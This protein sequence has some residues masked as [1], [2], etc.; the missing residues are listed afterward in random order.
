[1]TSITRGGEIAQMDLGALH[2]ATID[3][4]YTAKD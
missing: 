2:L 1:M 4:V 3:K